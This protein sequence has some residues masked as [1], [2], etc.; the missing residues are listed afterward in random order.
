MYNRKDAYYKQAKQEGY[1]SRAVYKLFDINAKH[2]VI[3]KG[4]TVLEV[5]SAPGG[6]TEG[7]LELVGRKGHVVCNDLLPMPVSFESVSNYDFV[8][9]DITSPVVK[10][11]IEGLG[12]KFRVLVSDA[13]PSTTGIKSADHEQSVHLVR[14]I[15]RVA[16]DMLEVGGSMLVKVFEG[17]SRGE[18][19]S[20]LKTSFRQVKVVK[21][22]SSRPNSV[23]IYLLC[24]DLKG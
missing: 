13:A 15:S 16:V 14:L 6:M 5:G 2:K 9:G 3:R 22:P 17:G 18:L 19:V 12:Y 20:E 24:T 1:Q 21:P 23:E 7:L 10:S 11:R 4:D 8:R